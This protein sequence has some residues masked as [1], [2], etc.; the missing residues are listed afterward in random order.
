MRDLSDPT[1]R[2]SAAPDLC[3]GVEEARR[4]VVALVLETDGAE[5]LSVSTGMSAPRRRVAVDPRRPT[6]LVSAV[7]RFAWMLAGDD[8]VESIAF[9]VP[10]ALSFSAD[11]EHI[12][13]SSYGRRLLEPDGAPDQ[14]EAAI[15]RLREVPATR[16]AAAV[17]WTPDDASREM[18]DIPCAF[19]VTYVVRSGQLLATTIMR[20][21]KPF[22]IMGYN[23]FEFSMLAEYVAARLGVALGPYRHWA[24][25]M[26]VPP[27]EVEGARALLGTTTRSVEMPSMPPVADRNDQ[28]PGFLATERAVRQAATPDDAI[29]RFAAGT[30]SLDPYWGALN[31]ILLLGVLDRFGAVDAMA[32]L[33]PLHPFLAEARPDV[34]G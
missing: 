30:G 14:I 1:I 21:N 32:G 8:R 3:E 31:Q 13:G 24:S 7:A 33:R 26:H 12:P 28:V 9:Y 16:R 34:W 20:S 10:G 6:W 15:S 4:A 18:V 2:A 23:F 11:G 25:V 19:G 29:D 17:V 27:H 22:S 5:A